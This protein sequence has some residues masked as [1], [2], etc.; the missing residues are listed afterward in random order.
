[1]KASCAIEDCT[2]EVLSR[3]W[4]SKHYKRWQVHGDPLGGRSNHLLDR[5]A[6]KFTVGDGCWEWTA[7]RDKHGY[8][9]IRLNGIPALAHRVVYEL[10]VGAIP[11]GLFALHHCDNPG[12][13]RPDH[14]FL[15]TQRD[16]MRD[17]W[18]KG[19]SNLQKKAQAS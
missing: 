19:R 14:I 17:M 7:H 3:I 9:R 4:C 15:G 12:C 16:N 5:L 11:E 8:G 10:L 6:D 2:S 18:K 13:V 1:M